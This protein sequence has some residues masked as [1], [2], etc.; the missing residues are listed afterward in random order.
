MDWLTLAARAIALA[1]IVVVLVIAGWI[2]G[3]KRPP[4]H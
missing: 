1:L 3:R 2:A 4:N